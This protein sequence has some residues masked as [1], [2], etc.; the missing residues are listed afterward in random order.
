MRCARPARTGVSAPTATMPVS[1]Y[2]DQAANSSPRRKHSGRPSGL[3]GRSGTTCF[4]RSIPSANDPKS[5]ELQWR[6]QAGIRIGIV[7]TESD[8]SIPPSRARF[9]S[10]IAPRRLNRR[11]PRHDLC[12]RAATESTVTKVYELG[13][14]ANTRGPLIRTAQGVSGAVPPTACHLF[15]DGRSPRENSGRQG[16]MGRVRE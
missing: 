15:G 12:L 3:W 11:F 1:S 10:E 9:R 7:K 6:L 13:F 8:A 5:P 4:I 14:V 2:F 16:W